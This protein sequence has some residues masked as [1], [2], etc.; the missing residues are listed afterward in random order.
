MFEGSSSELFHGADPTN[1]LLA[2]GLN[3]A[4]ATRRNRLVALTV[5]QAE[6]LRE[7]PAHGSRG[8]NGSLAQFGYRGGPGRGS[9]FSPGSKFESIR[10]AYPPSGHFPWAELGYPASAMSMDV[11][12]RPHFK[13]AWE[14]QDAEEMVSPRRE[15]GSNEVF[16]FRSG[17]AVAPDRRSHAGA[18]GGANL[19]SDLRLTRMGERLAIKPAAANHGYHVQRPESYDEDRDRRL[20]DKQYQ[21]QRQLEDARRSHKGPAGGNSSEGER[22][23]P[24]SSWDSG[25]N[26]RVLSKTSCQEPFISQRA[27]DAPVECS[28]AAYKEHV[29]VLANCTTDEE[30]LFTVAWC[31]LLDNWDIVEWVC[32]L[33]FSTDSDAADKTYDLL[34]RQWPWRSD[35]SCP[36][37]ESDGEMFTG[38]RDIFGGV[39]TAAGALPNGEDPIASLVQMFACGNDVVRSCAIIQT[40][41][42]LFHELTH[43]TGL[44]GED[45]IEPGDASSGCGCFKSY[46]AGNTFMWAMLQRYPIAMN[47]NSGPEAINDDCCRGPLGKDSSA[48]VDDELLFMQGCPIGPS[49]CFPSCD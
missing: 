48:E 15:P 22:F 17:D 7:E 42:V 3:A 4:T 6:A 23:S 49:Q 39:I 11:V 34:T 28:F 10:P 44:V 36:G 21:M 19:S 41:A 16:T 26:S 40:A 20:Q 27:E 13:F 1:R 5:A 30:E 29:N 47:P 38:R 2:D 37:L 8:F 12:T 18:F 25:C 14:A 9:K 24:P 43:L 45:P 31:V 32:C 33:V 35:I 46:L